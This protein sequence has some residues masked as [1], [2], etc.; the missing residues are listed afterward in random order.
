VVAEE[1]L[2]KVRHFSILGFIFQQKREKLYYQE[3]TH[4]KEG[5]KQHNMLKHFWETEIEKSITKCLL[6]PLSFFL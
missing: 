1:K 6:R 3:K 2:E 5:D 4:V